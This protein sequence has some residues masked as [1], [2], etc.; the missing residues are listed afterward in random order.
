M[1]EKLDCVKSLPLLLIPGLICTYTIPFI[2]KANITINVILTVLLL[3]YWIWAVKY[4]MNKCSSEHCSSILNNRENI[5]EDITAHLRRIRHEHNNH[6]QIV[7][8]LA[9]LYKEQRFIKYLEKL[10]SLDGI[11]GEIIKLSNLDLLLFY[12]NQYTQAIEREEQFY[13]VNQV[14]FEITPELGK[15]IAELLNK[16]CNTFDLSGQ[17]K[18]QVEKRWSISENADFY[19]I[20]YQLTTAQNPEQ[21]CNEQLR[22]ELHKYANEFNLKSE[23]YVKEGSCQILIYVPKGVNEYVCR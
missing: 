17:D 23:C 20:E 13:F 11:Y 7:Y 5:R 3:F 6:F 16:I 4:L 14:D 21:Y 10:K 15:R 8:S 22:K 12:L 9:Q 19:L 2:F 1:L 18:E